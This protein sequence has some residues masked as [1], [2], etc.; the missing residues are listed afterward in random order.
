MVVFYDN[1]DDELLTFVVIVARHNGKTV[2]CKHRKR[3]TYE[4]AGGHREPDE[5]I[6]QAAR[7]ELYEETG[8]TEYSLSSVCTY[9]VTRG[10]NDAPTVNYGMIFYAEVA[11]FERDLHYE[12][13]RIELF[14]RM[15]DNTTYPD[16]YPH[17]IEE[18]RRRGYAA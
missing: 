6:E 1:V 5:S 10:T 16:I 4:L 9:R 2:Y 17:I 13:E 8:A 18:M 11:A 14:D 12:I 15:P 3:D 7:R